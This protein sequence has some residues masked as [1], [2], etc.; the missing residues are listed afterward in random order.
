M[1]CPGFD[2][3]HA[4]S[5]IDIS[6]ADVPELLAED[7]LLILDVRDLDSHGRGHLDGARPVTD[8]V[9]RQLV[10][11]R[12]PLRPVLVY[13]HHG[14]SSC[15]ICQ[16]VAG[17]G[18]SRVYNL[19]GGWQAW[20]QHRQAVGSPLDSCLQRQGF[21]PGDIHGRIDNGMSPLMVAALQGERA[22]VD[23]LLA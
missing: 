10:K 2:R 1:P 18:Y 19:A 4:M 13:C 7:D 14:N 9:L 6:A 5:Y 16:F 3:G 21:R 22:I 12:R 17:L 23:A 15:D 11:E 8:A 20:E